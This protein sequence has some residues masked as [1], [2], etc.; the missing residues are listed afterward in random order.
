MTVIKTREVMYV[1]DCFTADNNH[2]KY[3]WKKHCV[4]V[5][6]Y[7]PLKSVLSRHIVLAIPRK[8]IQLCCII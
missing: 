4:K 7:C 3:L 1:I 5:G 6:N 2:G 8:L